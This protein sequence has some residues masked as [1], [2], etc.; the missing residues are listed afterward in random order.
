MEGDELEEPLEPD[1]GLEQG[2]EQPEEGIETPEEPEEGLEGEDVAAEEEQRQQEPQE[3]YSLAGEK[4]KPKETV[5]APE[6]VKKLRKDHKEALAEI[7]ELKKKVAPVPEKLESKPKP[8]LIDFNFDED[9]HAAALL[10]WAEDER[11][12]K[13]QQNA[14][15]KELEEGVKTYQTALASYNEAKAKMQVDDFDEA[16]TEVV[17]TLSIAQQNAL[18]KGA[19]RPE[20]VVYLLGTHPKK[21]EELAAIKDRDRFIAAIARM[22][23][24]EVSITGTKAKPIPETGV[25]VGGGTR[26]ATDKVLEKLEAEADK[27]GDRTKVIEYKRKL[28]DRAAQKR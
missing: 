11:K 8:K 20:V 3:T 21:L 5:P 6:W 14:A 17:K 22:E 18:L 24:K 27:T 23:V 15:A 2:L 25:Q 10:E 13:E 16:E 7:R 26:G 19:V 12:I 9:Q 28:R 4:P 1:T